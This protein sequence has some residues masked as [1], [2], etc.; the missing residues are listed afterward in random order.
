M[1]RKSSAQN[2]LSS[3]KPARD[4]NAP[5]PTA[6]LSQIQHIQ[7]HQQQPQ[8]VSAAG[9]GPPL[10]SATASTFGF[11]RDY[12]A[13]AQT[14]TTATMARRDWD[15]QSHTESVVSNANTISSTATLIGST[16]PGSG[17]PVPTAGSPAIPQSTNLEL[18]REIVQKRIITLT[19]MRNVHDG[20]SHWFHTILMSRQDLERVFNNH[21]MKKRTHRFAILG[22]SLSGFFD[23]TNPQ[24][25]LRSILN[26]LTEYESSKEDSER[27]RMQRLFRQGKGKR[28]TVNMSDYAMSYADDQGSFLITPHLPFALDYSQVLLSLLDVLSEVYNKIAKILG[29]SVFQHSHSHMM[30]PLGA[31]SPHPGVSYLFA[32]AHPAGATPSTAGAWNGGIIG[33]EGLPFAAEKD[34]GDLS[35]TLWGIANANNSGISGP[36]FGGAGANAWAGVA[37]PPTFLPIYGDMIQ[38]IDGKLKVS[39]NV[40][41]SID[42]APCPGTRCG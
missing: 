13:Y 22:M 26:T 6:S 3:F 33:V 11:D 28:P 41:T 12:G 15:V 7:A 1:R 23:V 42:L 24:D 9:G 39:R 16:A 40:V 21:A 4:T 36:Q 17:L 27:P 38:K 25:L 5:P 32:G 31:L 8:G 34:A 18:L 10:P 30:G 37:V 14:P 2:L 20:R 29:P 35:G 19:Y